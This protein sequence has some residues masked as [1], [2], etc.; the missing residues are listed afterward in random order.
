M[1]FLMLFITAVGLS[2]DAFA[3]AMCKGLCMQ[4][5]RV[6]HSVLVGIYF[7]T[8]QAVMPLI[9]YFLGINFAE[10]IQNVD[11]WIAFGLL[12]F[13]GLKML[14]E[15]LGKNEEDQNGD[16]LDCKTMLALSLATSIDALAVG[17]SFAVLQTEIFSAVAVIGITTF[18][19]SAVG[20]K[21]GSAF[22][23]RYKTG[24][25]ISGGIILIGIGIKILI[26]HLSA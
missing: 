25:E 2:M 1:N 10:R 26:E 17:I 18:C 7:G 16:A 8:F 23:K 15:A 24:A 11:H 22:G 6:R 13:L 12:A 14:Y 20:V 19:L 3:V 4:R 21:I 5:F 9:G